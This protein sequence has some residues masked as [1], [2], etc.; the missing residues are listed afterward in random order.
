MCLLIIPWVNIT[1]DLTE[2]DDVWEHLTKTKLMQDV[3]FCAHKH[4]SSDIVLF[5]RRAFNVCL[6]ESPLTSLFALNIKWRTM[7]N[8]RQTIDNE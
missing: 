4:S 7:C 3:Y 8:Q 2:D 6:L 5:F 1:F